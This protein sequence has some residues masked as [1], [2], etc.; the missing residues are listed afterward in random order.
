MLAH[1][2]TYNWIKAEI[3]HETANGG[4]KSKYASSMVVGTLKPTDLGSLRQA[5]GAENFAE[6][7]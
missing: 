7:K 3:D 4:D 6:K 2:I 5:D 1:R